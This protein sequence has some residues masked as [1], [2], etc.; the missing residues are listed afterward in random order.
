MKTHAS[1][2]WSTKIASVGSILQQ[3][4]LTTKSQTNY[5]GLVGDKLHSDAFMKVDELKLITKFTKWGC[6]HVA[7]R[8]QCW[9][10]F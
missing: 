9:C 1:F 6:S 3:M 2:G 7:L 10:E 8:L 4:L 5:N